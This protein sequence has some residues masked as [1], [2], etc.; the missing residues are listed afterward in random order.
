MENQLIMLPSITFAMKG[1]DILSRHQIRSYIER[2]PMHSKT[3]SC[4][5]SL[6]VSGD[7]DRAEQILRENHIRTLGRTSRDAG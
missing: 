7:I 3:T 5:Y 1:R 2:T 6:N 4:G